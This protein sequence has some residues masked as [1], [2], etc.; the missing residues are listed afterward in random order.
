MTCSNLDRFLSES[1]WP[2]ECPSCAEALCSREERAT[3]R[4][5]CFFDYR[6]WTNIISLSHLWGD[7]RFSASPGWCTISPSAAT[8]HLHFVFSSG[9]YKITSFPLSSHLILRKLSPLWWIIS[10]SVHR[11]MVE[12]HSSRRFQAK[13][14]AYSFLQALDSES[15]H[16]ILT[17]PV[18]T[19]DD[20]GPIT[21]PLYPYAVH[22][23]SMCPLLSCFCL[24]LWMI[25]PVF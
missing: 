23:Y 6:C 18:C 2:S 13:C 9:R 11:W 14:I 7:A 1:H 3:S 10:S 25:T 20:Y 24:L 21:A 22:S 19:K 5:Y 12:T 16:P 15:K 17:F 8:I 4:V